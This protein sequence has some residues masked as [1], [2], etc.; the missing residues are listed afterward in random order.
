MKF[1]KNNT[2]FNFGSLRDKRILEIVLGHNILEKNYNTLAVLF[3]HKTIKVENQIYPVLIPEKNS[4]VTGILYDFNHKDLQRI[5]FYEE[6]LYKLKLKQVYIPK[7]QTYKKVWIYYSYDKF[8]I[9]PLINQTWMFSKFKKQV[10][11]FYADEVTK[12]M[13]NYKQKDGN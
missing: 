8:R 12:F 3:N 4:L 13:S 6:N 7:F 9:K 1:T 11:K 10:T 2:I 5:N